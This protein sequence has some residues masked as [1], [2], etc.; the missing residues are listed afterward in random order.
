ML[1]LSSWVISDSA[2]TQHHPA[3]GETHLL[4]GPH[5]HRLGV[6][7]L[8][9][10]ADF[11]TQV[12]GA[13]PGELPTG[14]AAYPGQMW[15]EWL[16]S[17]L[18]IR[19]WPGCAGDKDVVADEDSGSADRGGAGGTTLIA[20]PPFLWCT[21][22][23]KNPPRASVW[24]RVDSPPVDALVELA[25]PGAAGVFLLPAHL[26]ILSEPV[27]QAWPVNEN[28]S[29]GQKHVLPTVT[30]PTSHRNTQLNGLLLSCLLFF[31]VLLYKSAAT[32]FLFVCV[33]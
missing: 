13:G 21:A 9:L 22:T 16:D 8:E 31:F 15:S 17:R 4:S 26:T 3:D 33:A 23:M 11:L 29:E 1:G 27:E 19:A 12:C 32:G 28:F 30:T 10:W 18:S 2:P 20:S 7:R 6:V 5:S 25:Q 24:T 14:L